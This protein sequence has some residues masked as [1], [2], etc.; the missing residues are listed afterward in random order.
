MDPSAT[1]GTTDGL[2]LRKREIRSD[3]NFYAKRGP[4]VKSFANHSITISG[5]GEEAA[6]RDFRD[7]INSGSTGYNNNRTVEDMV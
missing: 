2:F 3:I 1:P 4:S 5:T 6:E 7:T